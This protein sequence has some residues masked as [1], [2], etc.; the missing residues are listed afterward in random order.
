MIKYPQ[1]GILVA[2]GDLPDEA[3]FFVRRTRIQLTLDQFK[4][5]AFRILK[6]IPGNFLEKLENVEII[7]ED[8]PGPEVREELG[9]EDQDLL[10][11]LYRG[12]PRSGKSFFQGSTLPDRIT[13]F[14][15]PILSVAQTKEEVGEQIKKTLIHEIAHHF[16]FSESRI[17]E[18]GY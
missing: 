10:F 3:A 7:V 15:L 4:A 14:R 12:V 2:G 17:R 1:V 13:L 9:L 5:L 11:G 6:E 16:G 8:T 18:M